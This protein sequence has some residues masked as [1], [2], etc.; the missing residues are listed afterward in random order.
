LTRFSSGRRWVKSAHGRDAIYEDVTVR[1]RLP[2]ESEIAAR[3]FDRVEMMIDLR[4]R[5]LR[6]IDRSKEHHQYGTSPDPVKNEDWLCLTAQWTTED[7][8][9]LS[10]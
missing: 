4:A 2:G 5:F 8:S 9:K 7:E 10:T 3:H 6:A 1:F